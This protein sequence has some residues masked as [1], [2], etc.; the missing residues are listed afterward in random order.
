MIV[1]HFYK[2][3]KLVYSVYA[4]NLEEVK[5]EPLKYYTEYTKNM[6][7]VDK[8]FEHPIVIDEQIR[9]MNKEEKVER[10]IEVQ[11]Y[12]GEYIK[13]K[14][15]ILVKKPGNFYYWDNKQSKWILNEDKLKNNYF[16]I[17]EQYKEES[18]ESG[19]EYKY[20]DKTYIQKCREKDISTIS[21]NIISL[22][23]LE[24]IG[25]NKKI[26]WY[27]SDESYA[28]FG[29]KELQ[30]LM[31]FGVSF[32]Q[33]IYDTEHFFKTQKPK[34]NLIKEEFETKRKEIYNKIIG[35]YN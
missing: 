19:F 17:V 33:S 34:E 27:F 6:F 26:T 16:K 9:E 31:M 28:V 30:D 22:Q 32:V 11:L 15:L 24:K 2:D 13:D 7:I 3:I 21:T 5:R 18:L 10:N 20:K 35:E 12:D 25:I 29:L 14:K 1:V 4:N 23:T 8:E